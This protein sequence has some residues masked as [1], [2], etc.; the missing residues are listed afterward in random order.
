MADTLFFVYIIYSV[1]FDKY[2]VG[3][4]ANLCQRLATHNADRG[5]RYTSKYKPWIEIE[6]S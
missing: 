3:Q 5:H 2:Y 4:T 1:A 6:D